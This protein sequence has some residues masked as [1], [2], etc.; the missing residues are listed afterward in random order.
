MQM[1]AIFTKSELSQN[2][3]LSFHSARHSFA[4]MLLDA[5]NPIQT[6]SN[7]LGHKSI[8]TT[9]IYQRMKDK[10]LKEAIETLPTFL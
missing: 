2:R 4:M 8:E 1:K 6:I 7:A 9:M 3:K 10:H 5:G